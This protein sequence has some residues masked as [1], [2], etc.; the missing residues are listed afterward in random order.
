MGLGPPGVLA[1][2][3]LVLSK[4]TLRSLSLEAI[5]FVGGGMVM[6]TELMCEGLFAEKGPNSRNKHDDDFPTL[7]GPTCLMGY[8]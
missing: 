7:T 6:E 3:K 8:R 1:M 5:S 2:K 4:E